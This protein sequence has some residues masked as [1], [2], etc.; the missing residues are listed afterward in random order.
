MEKTTGLLANQLEEKE[1][2]IR[3]IYISTYLPRKCGIASFTK[4]LTNAV[5][6]LNPT[7][8]A[9]IMA[10][11][12]DGSEDFP[13]EVKFKIREQEVATYIDAANYI[14]SSSAD[15]VNLQHEFGIFGGYDGEYILELTSRIKKPLITTMHTVLTDPRPNQL[16]ITKKLAQ[17]SDAVIVMVE[18]ARER[19]IKIF[20]VEEDKIVV[21]HHGVPDIPYGGEG[22][23][24]KELGIGERPVLSAINLLSENKGLEYVIESMP[25][26]VKKFPNLLYLVIGQT[27]PE[28]LKH[29]GEKY[30]K[31][32]QEKV[33]QLGLEKNVRFINEYVSLEDLVDYL[34]ATDIY[35]TPYLDPEQTSSGTLAYA[36][37]AGK[38]CISTSY[39]YAKEVL[40][41]RRGILVPFK[42]SKAISAEILK[43]LEDKELMTKYKFDAYSF[44]RLMIWPQVALQNLDLMRLIEQKRVQRALV[45]AKAGF[46]KPVKYEPVS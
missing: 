18:S 24:K 15:V 5:N 40:A 45:S 4:D 28:V 37:G 21:I 19:L 7:N 10:V 13:W 14:N 3:A 11:T 25:A 30:R 23:Y 22:Y 12:K 8:L 31:L 27:H 9:E 6:V 2:K 43:V 29:D 42:S 39:L 16:R 36:L 33:K 34:R 41:D 38:V 46:H 17:T 1:R 44:G 35:I 32:L 26:I 20:G